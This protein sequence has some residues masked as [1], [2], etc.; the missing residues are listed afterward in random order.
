MPIARGVAGLIQNP[1]SVVVRTGVTKESSRGSNGPASVAAINRE[2]GFVEVKKN[3]GEEGAV[4]NENG[5]CRYG[6]V[7]YDTDEANS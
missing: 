2:T 3:I 5:G 7:R 1:R 4:I 6:K